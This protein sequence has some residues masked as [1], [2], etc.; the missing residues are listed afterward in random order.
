M[1]FGV[2]PFTVSDEKR[3]S[4]FCRMLSRMK[5]GLRRFAERRLG[6]LGA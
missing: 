6:E 4:A 2:L 3:A 1:V 5:N